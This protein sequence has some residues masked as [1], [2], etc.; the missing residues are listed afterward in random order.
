LEE[1][2]GSKSQ[3]WENTKQHLSIE[4]EV[5]N[6]ILYILHNFFRE[7]TNLGWSFLTEDHLRTVTGPINIHFIGRVVMLCATFDLPNARLAF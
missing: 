2:S 5:L 4:I 3:T 7:A 6:G 1:Q